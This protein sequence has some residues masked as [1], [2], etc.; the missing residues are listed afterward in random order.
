MFRSNIAR[1]GWDH[2]WRSGN[3]RGWEGQGRSRHGLALDRSD[4]ASLSTPL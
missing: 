4:V 3:V 2:G 1:M